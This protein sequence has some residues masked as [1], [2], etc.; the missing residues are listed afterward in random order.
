MNLKNNYNIFLKSL[1]ELILMSSLSSADVSG[2]VFKDLPLNGQNPNTYGVKDSNEFGIAEINVTAYPDG[3]STIT[4][5]NG[6]WSLATTVDSR[7]EFSN[8]PLYLKESV[9]GGVKN[10]SVQ[11]IANGGTANFALHNPAD[12][13]GISPDIAMSF[14]ATSD[15]TNPNLFSVRVLSNADTPTDGSYDNNGL[16][17]ESPKKGDKVSTL[18]DT[19]SVWGIAYNRIDKKLYV[20]SVVK[21]YIMTG[22]GG[23]GAIYKVDP[24]TSTTTLFTTILNV[25]T[26]AS[27]S[28]RKFDANE[29][30]AMHDPIFDE[31]GRVGLGDLDISDN[32]K[33]LYTVN[34]NTNDFV[35]IDIATKEQKSFAIGNPFDISCPSSD[36]KSWGIGQNRGKVYVGSV[37]TSSLIQ[38]AY[39]SEFNGT[40]FTPFHQIPLDMKGESSGDVANGGHRLKDDARWRI[41]ATSEE[42]IFDNALTTPPDKSYIRFSFPA[43]IVS[44]IVFDEKNGMIIGMIDRTTMQLGHDNY[45]PES[46]DAQ[47]FR[48]DSSGDIL[49]VC[50]VDGIYYNEGTAGCLQKT[51]RAKS[52]SEYPNY[53]EYFGGE[54]WN[55]WH[56][57]N[58]LG[59]LAYQQGSNRILLTAFN[60]VKK[61]HDGQNDNHSNS[62]IEWLDTIGGERTSGI[63][64]AGGG[65]LNKVPYGGKAGGI[66]D[67]EYLNAPAPIEIGD[68]VWLDTNSD[69]IQDA[70]EKGIA[71]VKIEL[72][73]AGEV[74]DSALTNTDGNYIFSN[75]PSG[76]TT[77]SH[78]Y[79]VTALIA[80]AS[81]C[82]IRVPNV[83]GTDKQTPLEENV[84]TLAN[85]GEGENNSSNDSD[86]ITNGDNADIAIFSTDIP[87]NGANNHSLDF[88]FTK[89]VVATYRL[90]DYVWKDINR[91]G[92]Q[93]TDESSGVNDNNNSDA[94]SDIGSVRTTQKASL[95]NFVWWDKNIDGV[96]DSD[97]LGVFDV[98][99]RLLQLCDTDTPINVA[100]TKTDENG[101]YLFENLEA[102]LYCL[103]FTS[104]PMLSNITLQDSGSTDNN[105]SDISASTGRSITTELL[106]GERDLSWDMGIYL[107]SVV[108]IEPRPEP[109]VA[110]VFPTDSSD[111]FD[112]PIYNDLSIPTTIVTPRPSIVP[113][114]T[115][116]STATPMPSLIPTVTPL[117]TATTTATI[118]TN[119]TLSPNPTPLPIGDGKLLLGDRVWID[120]SRNGLQDS[121][122]RGVAD[123]TIILYGTN[124]CTGDILG[125]TKT[126][127]NGKYLFG[128]LD[129]GRYCLAFTNTPTNYLFTQSISGDDSNNSDANSLGKISN[130]NLIS[131]DLTQ[132]VGIYREEIC[133]VSKIHDHTVDANT[134]DSTTVID[135]FS[136]DI[137]A[138]DTQTIS[139][140]TVEDAKNFYNERKAIS[141]T[142]LTK[143]QTLRVESEGVWEVKD[144]AIYFTALDGFNGIPSPVYYVIE[145]NKGCTNI[146]GIE[147]SLSQIGEVKIITPCVCETYE[148]VVTDTVPINNDTMV[149]I[150]LLISFL[151]ILFFKRE[152]F[153]K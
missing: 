3:L 27:N 36:V 89:L 13:I 152:E 107:S 9:E 1:F 143:F 115:P 2:I 37:C 7:I 49:R 73:C 87:L 145:Q 83:S 137:V 106:I 80:E 139:L 75:D 146:L 138:L 131:S 127:N 30:K 38:G 132:D 92:L 43:P 99:I 72:V 96:Q 141:T 102:G 70:N 56:G 114:S 85:I 47:L 16:Q 144:G 81:D 129:V 95:G 133:E 39:I 17:T 119:S 5:S 76:T 117:P 126:D 8:T 52:E 62:G 64:M 111:S 150:L 105:D 34:I 123:V 59:G 15:G 11:F 140:I 68:R 97:E 60:P 151:S 53:P 4:A 20:A 48:S 63:R 67:V 45:S 77:S 110:P 79:S 6:S 74:K 25:G 69:G 100:T 22:S 14:Q 136:N 112:T 18:S 35:E 57:E 31:V 65:G 46:N 58:S 41:W 42:E 91:D 50:Q 71:E 19:G 90:G 130:I 128:E 12:F 28:D 124:D 118:T 104:L 40:A 32:G 125:I 24:S 103:E 26:V 84:L 54:E 55:S 82:L 135:I 98:E 29:T 101:S 88:G 44:D 148:V 10:A 120:S 134:K 149:V 142:T 108:D 122:E 51:A 94:N 113:T 153:V 86:G 66:G 23:I 61:G 121:D 33:K 109:T 78:R 21:R 147:N 116:T 93:D